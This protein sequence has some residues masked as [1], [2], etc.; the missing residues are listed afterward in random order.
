MPRLGFGG[1]LLD[2]AARTHRDL[3]RPRPTYNAWMKRAAAL[4]ALLPALLGPPTAG[5]RGS[6]GTIGAFVATGRAGV[7]V[8]G[9]DLARRLGT[10][11][12][13]EPRSIAATIDAQRVVV[14]TPRGLTLI[15][16]RRRRAVATIG[17]F[18]DAR[19]VC[20]DFAGRYAYVGDRARR[21]LVAVD[22]ARRRIA[23]RVRLAAPP[24]QVALVEGGVAVVAGG[25]LVRVDEQRTISRI[26]PESA[27]AALAPDGVWAFV[28]ARDGTVSKL[29][30]ID[31]RVVRRIRLRAPAT[32]L[33]LDS[34]SHAVWAAEGRRAE[35][36]SAG[37]RL[38][39]RFNAGAPIRQLAPVGGWMAVVTAAGIRMVASPS[40]RPRERFPIPGTV[41]SVAFVVT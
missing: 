14:T 12:V 39:G 16:G 30:L 17:G 6:G 20:L 13:G 26:G 28:A 4:V 41:R 8:L 25:R 23:W 7:V 24:E 27:V 9:G 37:G 33:G 34:T 31:G 21:E 1:L 38:V 29:G 11:P 35:I 22:L 19:S 10:I 40:L 15:D 3:R 32:A 36:L 2:G 5:G 18:G